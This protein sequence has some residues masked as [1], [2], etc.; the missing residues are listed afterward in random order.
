VTFAGK[1]NFITNTFDHS[2][3]AIL[4]DKNI[5]SEGTY[6]HPPSNGTLIIILPDFFLEAQTFD[7]YI[8]NRD[9]MK[10]KYLE[11]ATVDGLLAIPFEAETKIILCF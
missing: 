3:D 9:L 10:V 11:F 1:G 7:V 4:F 8:Y 2:Q 5:S 6:Q